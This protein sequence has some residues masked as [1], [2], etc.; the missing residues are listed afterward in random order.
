MSEFQWQRIETAPSGYYKE[1]QKV[2]SNG[3]DRIVKTFVKEW[4]FVLLDDVVY[5][6]HKLPNGRWN[7]F[8]EWQ[9][10]DAWYPAHPKPQ[11]PK[12]G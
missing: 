8:C 10:G 7:G 4:C 3:K 12:G 1:E 5:L 11:P 9:K 6:T 2:T